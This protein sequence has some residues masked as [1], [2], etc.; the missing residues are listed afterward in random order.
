[1]RAARAAILLCATV[2]V[3]LC[4]IG[5]GAA[6]GGIDGGTVV[7]TGEE[8]F[9]CTSRP[10]A[11]V[12]RGPWRGDEV[13]LTFD[14]GPS[15]TQTPPIL[16]TLHRLGAH[17]TFFEEGRHVRGREALMRQILAFG[18]E[19]GNHSYHH[20]VDPGEGE[21]AST[22][23]AIRAATGF[24]PCLFRPPYGELD[25]KEEAAARAN[26]LELVFWTLDSEDDHHPGVGPIR[27]RVVRRTKPGSIV[28]LHDGGR[29]PQTVAALPGIVEGLEA[30]GFRLVTVTELLGGRTLVRRPAAPPSP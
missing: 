22:Q 3:G 8:A 26:G 29:H 28:L 1:M 12:H 13:A 2:G 23:A 16:E 6:R 5:A 21:L 10:G 24:T 17:A 11:I 7:G 18:D 30:R 4:L 14:D 25:R 27:A 20:P 19:I 15:L 9:G